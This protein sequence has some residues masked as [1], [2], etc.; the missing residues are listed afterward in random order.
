MWSGN[1]FYTH[2]LTTEQATKLRALLE[3]LGFEFSPSHT[4]YSSR[5]KI[6]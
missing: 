5:K 4:R 2:P 1:E 3:E 6:N